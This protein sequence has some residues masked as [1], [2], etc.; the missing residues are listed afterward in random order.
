V[1]VPLNFSVTAH[2]NVLVIDAGVGLAWVY[3]PDQ[4]DL[5]PSAT[6]APLNS[7][8]VQAGGVSIPMVMHIRT[9]AAGHIAARANIATFDAYRVST[10]GFTWARRN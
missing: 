3:C 7:L 5:A 10:L 6:A 2:L 4:T 8:S 1:K 9:S